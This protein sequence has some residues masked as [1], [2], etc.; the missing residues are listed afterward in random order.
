MNPRDES[1]HPGAVVEQWELTFGGPQPGRVR[2]TLGTGAAAFLVD[3]VVPDGRLVVADEDVPPPRVGLDLRA[4][5]LWTSLCCE[6]PFEHWTFGLEAFGLLLDG[7]PPD[8]LRWSE[9]VGERLAVGYDL[10][11]EATAAPE[12]LP[13]G[14]G[15]RI[16]GR[17]EGEV[18]TV[19][20]RWA[21]A[22]AATWEHWWTLPAH[23]S[24]GALSGGP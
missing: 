23:P 8:G 6:T 3:L 14:D 19:R 16:A 18:L 24:Q 12:P 11:W 5:G 21:V 1:A 20:E 22:A 7:P 17:V 10:E 13:G 9:L 2:L 15:Y 4:D